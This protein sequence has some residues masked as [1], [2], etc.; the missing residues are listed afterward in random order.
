[1]RKIES[2]LTMLDTHLFL[3]QTSKIIHR[4]IF[5]MFDYGSVE[6]IVKPLSIVHDFAKEKFSRI[7]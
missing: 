6:C 3:F 5:V 1:M 2:Y 4:D 7:G